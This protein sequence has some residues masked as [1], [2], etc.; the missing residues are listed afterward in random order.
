M[1][2]VKEVYVFKDGRT[3]TL[4]KSDRVYKSF[5][6]TTTEEVDGEVVER[7]ETKVIFYDIRKKGTNE[8]YSE[9]VDVL[10]Y[11][12]EEVSYEEMEDK[13]GSNK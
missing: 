5:E 12:Y 4:T 8:I 1:S 3:G 6:E 10:P 11:D 13:Y 7:T 2:I 9:A